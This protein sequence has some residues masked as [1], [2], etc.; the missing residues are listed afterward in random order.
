MSDPNNKLDFSAITFD[1]VVGEGAP[2]L[3]TVEQE[4]QDVEEYYD[5]DDIIDEDPREYGD[6]DFEDYVDEDDDDDDDEDTVEDDYDDEEDEEDDEEDDDEEFEDEL[7]EDEYDDLPIADKISDILGFEL[8]NEYA[9][10]VEG[11]TS[12]VRDMSEEVAEA[13]LQDLFDQYPEIQAHLDFVLAGGDPQEFY[14]AN[15]PQSD[16]SRIELREQDVTLQRAMLGEYYKAM[17]H[18]DEFIL[19]MLNDFEEGGKLYN[20]ALIAQG[21]LT[22]MQEQQREALYQ[23]Q[24]EMQAY[25]EEV[26]ENFWGDVADYISEDNEFAGIMIP[27]SDKQDFFDYIS[28]PVDEEGNTQRDLDYADANIDIKLAIDYLMYSGFDL[29]DIIDTKARTQSVRNLRER[30]QSNEERVKSARKAQ[31]RQPSFDPDQLDINALF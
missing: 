20:K 23:E 19:E 13:Q 16:Y 15:N 6:E 5:D 1:S 31:R 22:A 28:A 30:I 11:L 25:E 14:A 8:E 7:T 21:E 3:E 26:Q 18:Q 29:G 9:D 2:G 24:L 17:G 4:P 12:F 27:D 10:T